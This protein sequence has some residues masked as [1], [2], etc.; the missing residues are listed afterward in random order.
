MSD[1]LRSTP[2]PFL[3]PFTTNTIYMPTWPS[4]SFRVKTSHQSI[5]SDPHSTRLW[6]SL[7]VRWILFSVTELDLNAVTEGVLREGHQFMTSEKKYLKYPPMSIRGRGRYNQNEI[8]RYSRVA[9][10]SFPWHAISHC[11]YPFSVFGAHLLL[12]SVCKT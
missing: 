8:P 5:L 9:W 10:N 11:L 4:F 12:V 3:K 2:L 6:P 1:E 7:F